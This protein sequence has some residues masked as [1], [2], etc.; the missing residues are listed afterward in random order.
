MRRGTYSIVARD[1]RTGE[2]G[3]AVQS[4]WF[5]VGAIVPWVR[6]GVGAV[7]TQS[8]AEPA[9]GPQALD[10]LAAGARAPGALDGL[11]ADDAQARFRQVGVV[12]AHGDVAVHTGAGCVAHAG[13]ERGAGFTAQ[14]NMM[15]SAAVW[16]A[17]ARAFEAAVGPLA[18]RLLA[19][20]HAAQA[21][22]GDIRGRQSAALLV[23]PA[24]GEPWRRTVDLRVDDD[25]E[26]LAEL[27][28]LLDL[29]DAYDLATQGDELVGQG[30]HDEAGERY[31]RAAQLAPGNHELLFWAGL[32][33]AQAGDLPTAL[34]R[35]RRAIA[36][37]P[38][39]RELLDRL[40]PEIAPGAAVVRDAL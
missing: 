20:L 21:E 27:D 35:V 17:M 22:G 2:L 40:E 39:W 31:A 18:R 10:A 24:E 1:R 30:R 37:E 8:I 16:P 13:D 5:A 32:A 36:L 3:V 4:H 33:A 14:A 38:G 15:A 6:A 28:R 9:Y 7:A 26:P 23:A 25:P 12:D 19:A 11:L 29:A 34:E